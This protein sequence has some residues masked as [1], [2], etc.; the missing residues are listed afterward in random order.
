VVSGGAGPFGGETNAEVMKRAAEIASR[1]GVRG[2]NVAVSL[3]L[4]RRLVLREAVR[5]E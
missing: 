1:I 4:A 3:P 2:M 5:Q